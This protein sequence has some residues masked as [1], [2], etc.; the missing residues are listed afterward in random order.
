MDRLVGVN[1]R[2]QTW[3]SLVGTLEGHTVYSVRA[4][5]DGP[6]FGTQ[7]TGTSGPNKRT[8]GSTFTDHHVRARLKAKGFDN[9]EL[10]W[11]RCSLADVQ[12][13][14]TE[15]RTGLR[16]TMLPPPEMISPAACEIVTALEGFPIQE[17]ESVPL[18]NPS[19]STGVPGLVNSVASVSG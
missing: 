15:L 3:Q 11:M 8:E 12:T 19:C 5:S 10:E 13:V 17:L 18:S 16:I 1:T 9:T 4:T 7:D 6:V 14:L 2:G